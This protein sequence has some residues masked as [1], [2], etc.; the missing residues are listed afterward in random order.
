MPK[1]LANQIAADPR[2]DAAAAQLCRD[3]LG[4]YGTR[5]KARRL[6]A[7]R[8]QMRL[9]AGCRHLDPMITAAG[10]GRLIPPEVVSR[11]TIAAQLAVLRQ[12][13][14]LTSVPGPRGSRPAAMTPVFQ[15]LVGDW[16]T[17]V[18]GSCLPFVPG[19]PPDPGSPAV[20]QR[21]ISQ[22]VMATTR[23]VADMRADDLV[24]RGLRLKGGAFLLFEL[25]LRQ[26][27]PDVAATRFSRRGFALRF[28]LARTH[29]IDMLAE[30]AR[31]GWIIAGPNAPVLAPSLVAAGRQWLAQHLAISVLSLTG[32][33]AGPA[34]DPAT[35]RGQRAVASLPQAAG[36]SGSPRPTDV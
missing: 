24:E 10:L 35:P 22:F 14:M 34:P 25:M 31:Q 4:F 12:E 2:F 26:L 23:P 9:V 27:D 6:M 36:T 1:V 7:N 32:A 29:L 33:L 19:P 8:I 15:T 28:D 13:G 21:S 17:A 5:P 18:V 20:Q 11:N 30:A 3:L 16:V